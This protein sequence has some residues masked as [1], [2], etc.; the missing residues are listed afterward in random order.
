[1][2]SDNFDWHE[3]YELANSFLNEEDIAK[4][5]TGMG[6]YYYSSFL[7]SRDFILENNCFTCSRIF[8]IGFPYSLGGSPPALGLRRR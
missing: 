2:K 3:Y 4:L 8:F 7:E 5:R 6:R 1:M